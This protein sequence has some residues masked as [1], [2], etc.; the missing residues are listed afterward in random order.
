MTEP[1]CVIDKIVS[2]E[3][4]A[5]ILFEDELCIAFLD[6]RPLFLGHT[7]VAP[8]AHLQNIHELPYIQIEPYFSL[9]KKMARAV[10]TAMNAEGSFIA[11]NNTVSQ[12]IPHLHVHLVPRRKGDGLKGFFWPRTRYENEEQALAVQNKIIASLNCFK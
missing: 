1:S 3:E 9:V 8:K 5:F 2:R 7:L 11:M 4:R 10:E 6:N 12:S